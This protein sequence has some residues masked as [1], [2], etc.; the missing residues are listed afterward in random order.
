MNCY[1]DWCC[2]C[3][4]CCCGSSCCC[5]P[6]CGCRYIYLL[7][8]IP[9]D[10]TLAPVTGLRIRP[11]SL[12]LLCGNF[13]EIMLS[14]W[15]KWEAG[16]WQGVWCVCVCINNTLGWLDKAARQSAQTGCLL[17][18]LGKRERRIASLY[19]VC[20]YCPTCH[21]PLGK[22]TPPPSQLGNCVCAGIMQH[23]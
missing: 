9:L 19:A 23:M 21:I 22:P 8:C 12:C 16:E 17:L 5:A 7:C 4:C 20:I 6:R 15:P 3:S 11:A 18:G 10:S 2:C 13:I 1:W 14:N